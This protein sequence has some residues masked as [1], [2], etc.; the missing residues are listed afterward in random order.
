MF[1]EAKRRSETQEKA[2]TTARKAQPSEH[3]IIF[4]DGSEWRGRAGSKAL[5]PKKAPR[6]E[7]YY[8]SDSSDL[9][10]PR[11][12]AHRIWE[13]GLVYESWWLMGKRHRTDGPAECEWA[14]INGVAKKIS[15]KW[16]RHGREHRTDG[17]A[18][19][20]SD[21]DDH[22]YA[23]YINGQLHRA[24]A[25]AVIS[26]IDGVRS[27]KWYSRGNLHRENGPAVRSIYKN[28][29]DVV[30][31]E[32]WYID[33]QIHREAAPAMILNDNGTRVEKWY[34]RGKLHRLDGPAVTGT[35]VPGWYMHGNSTTPEKIARAI[36]E[37]VL[38]CEFV[39]RLPQ[40]IAEEIAEYITI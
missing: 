18:V 35:N 11:G 4:E 3:V 24:G 28:S 21:N 29:G 31:K 40:P 27:E 17:P 32:A 8:L 7:F 34:T 38:A 12:P 37:R 1:R 15:V 13:N 16:F 19:F 5:P 36:A 10:N 25:P 39:M 22:T 2:S 30:T 33:G 9:H 6:E 14:H 23:W 20:Y 26:L